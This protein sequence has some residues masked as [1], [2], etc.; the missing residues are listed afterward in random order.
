MILISKYVQYKYCTLKKDKSDNEIYVLHILLYV[1]DANL[2]RFG[3]MV[4]T[5]D[6]FVLYRMNLSA[7]SFQSSVTKF[8]EISSLCPFLRVHGKFH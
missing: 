7:T 6:K 3:Q 8:G 2:P 5:V 1:T 4:D